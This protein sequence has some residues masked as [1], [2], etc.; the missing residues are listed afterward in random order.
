MN[1]KNLRSIVRKSLEENYPVGAANDPRA[2]WNQVDSPMSSPKKTSNSLNFVAG[3]AGGSFLVKS[4]GRFYVI[5]RE[6]IENNPELLNNLSNEYGEV[7][8]EA[9]QDE[10]GQN[11]VYDYEGATLD[12][13]QVMNAA[14]D[15][16]EKGQTHTPEDFA[17]GEGFVYELT[18]AMAEELWSSGSEL[19][20]VPQVTRMI[21]YGK[22]RQQY[23]SAF[24]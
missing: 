10:D 1:R 4:V 14:E 20:S 5:S 3:D 9:E 8:Y 19:E 16:I 11:N 12:H 23:P 24:K 13:E 21:D 15:Y 7:P 18:P 17:A 2:P 6:N 22:L